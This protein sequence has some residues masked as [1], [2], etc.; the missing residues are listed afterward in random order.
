MS[1]QCVLVGQKANHT[2]DCVK[3]GVT[4]KVR[5]VTI[6]LYSALVRVPSRV[7]CPGF[8]PPVLTLNNSYCLVYPESGMDIVY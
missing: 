2:V 8:G 6:P 4:S 1:Q 3:R 7:L 5:E